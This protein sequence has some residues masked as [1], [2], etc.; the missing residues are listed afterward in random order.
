MLARKEQKS[1]MDQE[2]ID[3][4]TH[5]YALITKTTP[6][7]KFNERDI[8]WCSIGINVGYEINGKNDPV[9]RPVLIVKKFNAD[10]FFGL[11]LTTQQ[12]DY[13]SRYPTIVDGVSS[14]MVLDQAKTLS[15]QRLNRKVRRIGYKEF[16]NVRR[17]LL[18][19]LELE[20]I[21]AP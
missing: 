7:P 19:F 10:M 17:M 6:P 21:T 1:K 11:P 13:N 2:Y 18:D 15:A 9:E 14:D 5:K 4:Q 3:W 12:K 16:D 20:K 8:W